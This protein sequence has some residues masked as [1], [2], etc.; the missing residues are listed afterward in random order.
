MVRAAKPDSLFTLEVPW[1]SATVIL[2]H[3]FNLIKSHWLLELPWSM[4]NV[5]V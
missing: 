4:D 5:P 1:C 2:I 3:L